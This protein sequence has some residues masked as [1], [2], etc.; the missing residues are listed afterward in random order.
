MSWRADSGEGLAFTEGCVMWINL[1]P[2][3]IGRIRKG[4]ELYTALP[5]LQ[6]SDREQASTL[7]RRLS[8]DNSDAALISA[9]RDQWSQEEIQIDED[10]VIS[11]T[12]DGAWVMA[13]VWMG[14]SFYV[15]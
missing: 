6:A 12:D 15:A 5:G 9:A 1:S 11:E 7:L 8:K 14:E 10:A 4:L 13:W 2:D 3:E